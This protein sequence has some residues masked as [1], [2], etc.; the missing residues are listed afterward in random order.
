MAF[1]HAIFC[2]HEPA[3][4]HAGLGVDLELEAIDRF[5]AHADFDDHLGGG[6]VCVGEVINVTGDY[7]EIRF[8]LG[9]GKGEWLFGTDGIAGGEVLGEPAHQPKNETRMKGG[10]GHFFDERPAEQFQIFADRPAFDHRVVIGHADGVDTRPDRG[11]FEDGEHE[12]DVTRF[13]VAGKAAFGA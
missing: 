6:R 11:V 1:H 12:C 5:A 2:K 8:G 4:A 7:R 13:A 10:L 3:F 9:V